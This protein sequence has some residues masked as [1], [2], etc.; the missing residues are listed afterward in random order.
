MSEVDDLRAEIE[1]LRDLG[2]DERPTRAFLR[3]D[4]QGMHHVWPEDQTDPGA[5]PIDLA[6]NLRERAQAAEADRD[7][8]REVVAHVEALADQTRH[9]GRWWV[10][11]S[12]LRATLLTPLS[13]QPVSPPEDA[14]AEA[15]PR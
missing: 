11:V 7:R 13:G 4:S 8:L 2:F 12:D 3:I 15:S 6:L 5:V 9:R 14:P 10:H 1:R